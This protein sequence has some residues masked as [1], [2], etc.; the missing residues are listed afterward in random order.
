L[1]AVFEALGVKVLSEIAALTKFFMNFA[2]PIHERSHSG[3]RGHTISA[4]GEYTVPKILNA[5][6]N[7]RANANANS[8]FMT[9]IHNFADGIKPKNSDINNS[10]IDTDDELEVQMGRGY[11]L[12]KNYNQDDANA[13]IEIQLDRCSTETPTSTLS[14]EPPD[15]DGSET[16]EYEEEEEVRG[17][18]NREAASEEE[19]P[20]GLKN[21]ASDARML[22]DLLSK[23]KPSL[24]SKRS[25]RSVRSTHTDSHHVDS[26]D[27]I[28][29]LKAFV[30]HHPKFCGNGGGGVGEEEHHQFDA[31]LP[32]LPTDEGQI[33]LVEEERDECELERKVATVFHTLEHRHEKTHRTHGKEDTEYWQKLTN[34]LPED[35]LRV[36]KGLE[37]GLVHLKEVLE[38]RKTLRKEND[39]IRKQNDELRQLL[40]QHLQSGVNGALQQPPRDVLHYG[41]P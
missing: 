37:S 9:N 1:D 38:A 34:P 8:S 12:N 17:R 40:Q 21:T 39:D 28:R 33:G 20:H 32:H 18:G 6:A 27:V 23:K 36:W 22:G 31:T 5:N 25:E 2:G 4:L 7:A 3:H 11:S 16:T 14:W 15:N 35:R 13:R 10:K 26:K 19:G 24:T 30:A 29:A 41:P